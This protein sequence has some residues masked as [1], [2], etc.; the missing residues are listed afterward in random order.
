MIADDSS[1]VRSQTRP[2]AV[3]FL[4]ARLTSSRLPAKQLR[5]IGGRPLMEWTI[6][7]LRRCR[8]LDQ[9]VVATVSEPENEPLR[10]F[11]RIRG[12]ECFWFDGDVNHVTTR[13]RRAAESYQA[14][15]GVLVSGD[16]PLLQAEAVDSLITA[17]EESE[18]ADYVQIAGETLSPGIQGVVVGRIRSWQMAD[19]LADRPEL[20]EHQ[21]PLLSQRPDLFQPVRAV[22]P[23]DLCLPYHRLSVDT[24]ADLEF[25]N[26]VWMRVRDA[27]RE[28]NLREAVRLLKES[29]ELREINL[30][31][32]QRTVA[33]QPRK[34]LCMLDAGS[35]YGFG[36]LTRSTE[37]ARQIVERLGWPVQFVVDD[38]DA[39]LKLSDM[40][41][42]VSWGAFGRAGRK[43]GRSVPMFRER[44]E[45]F[46][47][48]I[49]DI[50]DQRGPEPGWRERLGIKGSV[51]VLENYREWCRE[52]D[53]L[54]GPNVLNKGGGIPEGQ[55]RI[56]EGSSCLI[57]RQEVRRLKG[58]N[59]GKD[60]DL[61]AYLHDPAKREE[62]RVWAAQT[63]LCAEVPERFS[64]GFLPMM[65]RTRT[66]LSGF[67]TSFYESLAL[68]AVPICW[69][70]SDAHRT[71]AESF[72]HWLGVSPLIVESI[73][74]LGPILTV[75]KG[76]E[77]SDLPAVE[78]GTP[79]IV[80][81]LRV[82]V[83]SRAIVK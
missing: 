15:I 67:G 52:A 46:D 7:E 1:S 4:V 50:F 21:F 10:E 42:V 22:L 49:L 80:E 71:D 3:A 68:G 5:L 72:Y 31:V 48:V 75:V 62:V 81:E 34:V 78:D 20:K 83:E 30:H 79:R 36:H 32:H 73:S 53:L 18:D 47:L 8:K 58:S 26:A 65:A 9:I 43:S 24:L 63:G 59:G 82:L 57:L 13:L 29:P 74:D 19:E 6:D 69:P 66:F 14:D 33:E 25:F 54:I 17:L 61:L 23:D 77:T 39:A 38:D 16:C 11:C 41:F 28:F 40:G 27:G 55:L 2:R 44:F 12:L 45:Q 56:I 51:A 37:L 60:L 35:A 76:S 70:D 64:S